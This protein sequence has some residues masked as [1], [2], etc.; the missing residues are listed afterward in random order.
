MSMLRLV[1]LNAVK[2]LIEKSRE[3]HNHKP[4]PTSYTKRKRKMTKNNTCK[5]NKQ[6]HETRTDQLPLFQ[7]K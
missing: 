1:V 3:C 2:K 4:Q 5:G 6:M 7:A